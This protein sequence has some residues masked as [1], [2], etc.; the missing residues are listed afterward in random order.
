MPRRASTSPAAPPADRADVRTRFAKGKS[1]NA[2][3]RPRRSLADLNERALRKL[4]TAPETSAAH[5]LRAA[6]LLADIEA[7]RGKAE[8]VDEPEPSPELVE[9]IEQC[10]QRAIEL[11]ASPH[12][13]VEFPPQ[14]EDA[15]EPA[16]MRE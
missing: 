2:K 6:R 1:G 4:L 3:G 5:R 8:P 11:L 16:P 10:G 12:L 7:R 13:R 9:A 15:D 14:D